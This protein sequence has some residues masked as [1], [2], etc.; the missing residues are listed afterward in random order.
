MTMLLHRK[1]Q[2]NVNAIKCVIISVSC[3]V[4]VPKNSKLKHPVSNTEFQ[5]SSLYQTLI[6]W[7]VR[8]L[9]VMWC[10]LEGRFGSRHRKGLFKSGSRTLAAFNL[11][12]TRFLSDGSKAAGV[13]AHHSPPSYAQVKYAYRLTSPPHGGLH[14]VVLNLTLTNMTNWRP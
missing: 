12:G 4:S 8:S 9:V 11:T 1:P 14:G 6:N 5:V 10:G 13:S 3:D 7:I 2:G